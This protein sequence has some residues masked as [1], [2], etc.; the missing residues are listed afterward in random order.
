[1]F[2]YNWGEEESS[3]ENVYISGCDYEGD[4]IGGQCEW[5]RACNVDRESCLGEVCIGY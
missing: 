1:M 4:N 3:V 2:G 5:V